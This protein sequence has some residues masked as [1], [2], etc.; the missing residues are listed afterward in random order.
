MRKL[1]AVAALA[2]PLSAFADHNNL[3]VYYVPTA[4]LTIDGGGPSVDSDG[5]KGWGIKGAASFLPEAF[6]T[7]EYQRDS[8]DGFGGFTDPGAFAEDF[9]AGVG[10]HFQEFFYARADFIH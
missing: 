6:V 10:M 8:Y 9:R 7:W 1:L 5:G 2:A 3:D 4:K